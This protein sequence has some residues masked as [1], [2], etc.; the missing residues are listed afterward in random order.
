MMYASVYIMRVFKDAE[1]LNNFSSDVR[2]CA[3][4][5]N[6]YTSAFSDLQ[7]SESKLY[8]TSIQ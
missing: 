6:I 7:G 5:F 1:S 3:T 4:N 2:L 8:S